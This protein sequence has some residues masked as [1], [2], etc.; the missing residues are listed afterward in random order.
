MLFCSDCLVCLSGYSCANW[1]GLCDHMRDAPWEDIFKL[2]A[3]AVDSEFCEWVEVGVV[4]YIPHRKYHVKPH[5]S[6]WFSTA[7]AAAIA[8]KNH[9]FRLYQQNKSSESKRKFRQAS[10][11]CKK[12]LEAVIL[13]YANNNKKRV[14]HFPETWLLGLLAHC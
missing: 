5:S 3:F 1:D 11:S 14:Y 7:W 13:A 12:V 10:D 8:H 9:F 6:P 2:S 4:V